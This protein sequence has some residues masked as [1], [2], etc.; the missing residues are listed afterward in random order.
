MLLLCAC[1]FHSTSDEVAST[2]IRPASVVTSTM[3]LIAAQRAHPNLPT[4]QSYPSGPSRNPPLLSPP[5]NL[6]HE[7][8]RWANNANPG[9]NTNSI[10]KVN[11]QNHPNSNSPGR[12]ESGVGKGEG[13]GERGRRGRMR[14]RRKKR[15]ERKK[16]TTHS[17]DDVFYFLQLPPAE[18]PP[19]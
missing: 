5:T 18:S 14:T 7:S 4:S 17:V 1:A 12:R 10:P 15:R 11:C 3:N 2:L 6:I 9:V 13:M 8:L 16:Y 19:L